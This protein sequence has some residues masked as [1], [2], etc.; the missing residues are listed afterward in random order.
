MDYFSPERFFK[1]ISESEQLRAGG[2]TPPPPVP[3]SLK[4]AGRMLAP[5]RQ[6]ALAIIHAAIDT[7]L[8]GVSG[9]ISEYF[10]ASL[11]FTSSR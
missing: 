2:G 3:P 7:T 8:P 4:E 6:S 5:V 1:H 9:L 11:G 10:L